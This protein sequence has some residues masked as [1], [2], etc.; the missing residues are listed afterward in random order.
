[1]TPHHLPG[2]ASF[3]YW[4]NFLLLLF[5]VSLLHFFLKSVLSGFLLHQV[6]ELCRWYV[7]WLLLLIPVDIFKSLSY[8]IFEGHLTL[9]IV[10]SPLHLHAFFAW[11]PRH[12]ALLVFFLFSWLL[13][14]SL[15]CWFL[16]VFLTKCPGLSLRRLRFF[17]DTKYLGQA[18]WIVLQH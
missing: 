15:F 6:P 4:K 14:F 3:R 17:T 16:L 5:P 7:Q 1:M 2:T 9:L 11:F 13:L 18:C 8:V 12:H 10:L